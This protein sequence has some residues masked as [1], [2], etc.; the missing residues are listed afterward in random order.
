MEWQLTE[1]M[2]EMKG[3]KAKSYK[4]WSQNLKVPKGEKKD[5]NESLIWT[6]KKNNNTAKKREMW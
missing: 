4:K 6:L 5:L 3:K 1:L 2:N